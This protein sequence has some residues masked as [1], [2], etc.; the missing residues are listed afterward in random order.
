MRIGKVR[1]A[2][3]CHRFRGSLG[4]KGFPMTERRITP[5][6]SH[7]V[8]AGASAQFTFAVLGDGRP[9]LAPMPYSQVTHAIMRELRLLQPAF[10]LYTGDRIW[11][12]GETPQ[13]MRNG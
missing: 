11:G 9:A 12:F 5:L 8:D 7:A 4:E 1:T 10:V 13:E 2:I 6:G 3:A